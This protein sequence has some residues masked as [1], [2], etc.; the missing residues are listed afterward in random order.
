M[1]LF[2]NL[3]LKYNIY[4]ETLV[5]HSP[6]TKQM[7]RNEQSSLYDANR[8]LMMVLPIRSHKLMGLFIIFLWAPM[9]SVGMTN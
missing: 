5:I 1:A 7:I 3:I 6:L 2:L 8:R 4:K 9:N